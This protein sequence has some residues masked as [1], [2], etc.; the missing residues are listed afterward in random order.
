MAST[1]RA[2]RAGLQSAIVVPI[3]SGDAFEGVLE[4]FA[5]HRSE[6]D[7]D[8]LLWLGTIGAQI[9]Q[10]L[11]RWNAEDALAAALGRTALA[12]HLPRA[13]ER[14]ERNGLPAALLLCDVDSEDVL[15]P[16]MKPG[17]VIG[18]QG[19]EFA[20]LL[21]DL[22][23]RTAPRDALVAAEAIRAAAGRTTSVGVSLLGRDAHDASTLLRHAEVALSR[24]MSAGGGARIHR[25]R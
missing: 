2:R 8:I 12:E 15:R 1:R 9:G 10:Y 18:R 16:V 6:P 23:P 19:E 7:G 25:T 17:D 5:D 20:L 3:G 24:A 4:F 13:V 11:A 14:A 22:G 21:T